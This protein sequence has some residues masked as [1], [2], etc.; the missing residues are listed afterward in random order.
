MKPFGTGANPRKP[1]TRDFKIDYNG[2]GT[3]PPATLMPNYSSLPVKNQGTYGTCGGHAGAAL[4]SFLQMLDLS[5]KF[6]WKEIK[7]TDGLP[8]NAGTDMRYIFQS[9]QNQGTCHETLCPDTLDANITVYSDASTITQEMLTDAYPYGVSNYAFTDNPTWA[10]IQSAIA[11]NLVVIALMKCGT[12][13]WTAANGTESYA[14][15]DILPLRL[16]TYDSG[17]FVVLWGYDEKYI[18]FRNSWGPTWGRGGDGYFDISYLP[19]ITEIGTAIKSISTK[20]KLVSL[21]TQL[22]SVLTSLLSAVQGR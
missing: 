17:H 7:T 14:E 13:W 5:P 20:Q 16:G 2:S 19:N 22:V 8:D 12:G 15:A 21:Y 3:P 4:E 11:D 6:L 18:Y 1:D 9:L 10:Q